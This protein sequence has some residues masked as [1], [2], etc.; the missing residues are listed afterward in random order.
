[1]N[2]NEEQRTV[3]REWCFSRVLLN[4]IPGQLRDINEMGIRIVLMQ[5]MDLELDSLQQIHI[6]PDESLSIPSFEIQGRLRW[7]KN[8]PFGSFM[9][10][11]VT[12]FPDEKTKKTFERLLEYYK[13]DL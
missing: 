11:Q 4:G 10:F 1:M 8:D 6:L 9:G 3:K 5:K 7:N 13:D 12:D 2:N